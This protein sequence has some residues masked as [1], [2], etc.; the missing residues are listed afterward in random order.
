MLDSAFI[1]LFLFFALKGFWAGDTRELRGILVM[2]FTLFF[3]SF[4]NEDISLD[5]QGAGLTPQFSDVMAFV[6]TASVIFPIAYVGLASLFS[7]LNPFGKTIPLAKR[8]LGAGI[9]SLKGLCLG[10]LFANVLLHVPISSSAL[11]HSKFLV[12]F[13]LFE[14]RSPKSEPNAVKPARVNP[15]PEA[16]PKP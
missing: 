13:D 9:G 4:P 3:A 16:K 6:I 2:G 5:L 8:L 15:T 7:E 12:A 10:I 1:I 11:D 14:S